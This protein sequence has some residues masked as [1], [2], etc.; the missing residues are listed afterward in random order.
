MSRRGDL[1]QDF[2]GLALGQ[3][4]AGPIANR[5][6]QCPTIAPKQAVTGSSFPWI[7]I[8]RCATGRYASVAQSKNCVRR[9]K[10]WATPPMKCAATLNIGKG[11]AMRY[12][13]AKREVEEALAVLRELIQKLGPPQPARR[14]EIEAIR[15]CQKSRR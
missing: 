4:A 7:K 14:A 3:E 6:R 15:E 9:W 2:R 12:R 11:D 5:R 1:M 10:R 8:K 13:S